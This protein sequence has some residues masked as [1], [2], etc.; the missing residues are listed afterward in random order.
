MC[1][2]LLETE[3]FYSFKFNSALNTRIFFYKKRIYIGSVHLLLHICVRELTFRRFRLF[4][5]IC[6]QN[7]WFSL[8]MKQKVRY[9]LLSCLPHFLSV[10]VLQRLLSYRGQTWWW[11]QTNGEGNSLSKKVLQLTQIVTKQSSTNESIV[12]K[13]YIWIRVRISLDINL[14][15]SLHYE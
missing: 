6:N 15:Y 10:W 5:N 11:Y 3:A 14:S 1:E 4:K 12:K 8:W 13:S 2:V 9:C 7:T